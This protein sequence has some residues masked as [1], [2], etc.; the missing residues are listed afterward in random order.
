MK[1]NLRVLKNIQR[2]ALQEKDFKTLNE[3]NKELFDIR[4]K[5]RQKYLKEKQLKRDEKF[6]KRIED[7]LSM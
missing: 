6:A 7:L 4:E 2:R 3:V 5:E 1:E